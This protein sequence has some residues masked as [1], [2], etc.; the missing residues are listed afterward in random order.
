M[1]QG[2]DPSANLQDA[3]ILREFSQLHD[4]VQL[5]AIV[6]KILPQ[7][8]RQ[9]DPALIQNLPHLTEPHAMPSPRCSV[10]QP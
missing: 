6:K 4:T 8:F 7:R 10:A 5:I 3:I 1:G 2:S 9:L